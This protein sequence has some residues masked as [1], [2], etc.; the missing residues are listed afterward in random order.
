MKRDFEDIEDFVIDHD[1]INNKKK[2]KIKS[3]VKGKRGEREI[4]DALNTRFADVFK[5]NSTLG[6]FSRSVASGAR[7]GQ[8]VVLSQSAM[9]NFSGDITC[10]DSFK[11]VIESKLGYN[12]IDLYMCFT[13]KCRELD[14]FLEQVTNDSIRCGR[15]PMLIWKKDRKNK[16]T[17]IKATELKVFPPIHIMYGTW[18]GLSFD[19]LLTLPDEYFFK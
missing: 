4:V 9:N 11:F 7:W 13:G 8:N 19:W 5:S 1:I 10:P 18:I 12:D 3:G 2:K 14:N 6:Q 15:S 16:L 17:F